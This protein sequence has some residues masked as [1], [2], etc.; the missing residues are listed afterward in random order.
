MATESSQGQSQGG[1]SQSQSSG[2]GDQQQS[3]KSQPDSP[4]RHDVNEPVEREPH[5]ESGS[6][7]H[8]TDR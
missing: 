7:R 8:D 3:N 6:G 2:K 1:K 4:A 5:R